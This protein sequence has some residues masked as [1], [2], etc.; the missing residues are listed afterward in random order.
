MPCLF[1]VEYSRIGNPSVSNKA[2]LALVWR[3]LEFR[4]RPT[5][6]ARVR[7]AASTQA[8]VARNY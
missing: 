6:I 2:E 4:L 5:S 7:R 8:E 3:F 1:P